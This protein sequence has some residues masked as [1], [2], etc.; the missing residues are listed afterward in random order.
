MAAR[1]VYIPAMSIRVEDA[2]DDVSAIYQA[3]NHAFALVATAALVETLPE[4]EAAPE[5]EPALRA[6]A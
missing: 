4:A 6:V 2:S 5:Q 3:H 1:I